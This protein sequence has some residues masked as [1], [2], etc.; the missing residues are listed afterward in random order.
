[1]KGA[2]DRALEL[3]ESDPSAVMLQQFEN[4]AN[5][6]V[7]W[8]TTGPEIWRDSAGQVD[9]LVCGVG[10]GGTI[11]GTG[12]YLRSQNPDVHIVAV[13]PEESA[14]LSGGKPGPHKIQGIGAGFVPGVLNTEIYDEV[15]QV[16][17][18]ASI[19]MAGRLATEEV[20][21]LAVAPCG[22]PPAVL[23]VA[24]A[25]RALYTAA[26]VTRRSCA[27]SVVTFLAFSCGHAHAM[28][29]CNRA[30]GRDVKNTGARARAGP[31]LRHLVRCG[32]RGGNRGSEAPRLCW[33]ARHSGAAKLWRA[34]PLHRAVQQDQ[35]G[36]REHEGQ[37]ARQARGHGG[38]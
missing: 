21:T 33:Q 24:R 12:E 13:E 25:A 17:G 26:H 1:M 18:A 36:V 35:G 2:V 6:D 30:R 11:T 31:V 37:R 4:P 27:G 22:P 7:H 38:A 3:T 8:A 23:P 9:A 15:I 19:D 28:C 5:R 20:R 29:T 16:S 10:T 14:V 34:L 32:G